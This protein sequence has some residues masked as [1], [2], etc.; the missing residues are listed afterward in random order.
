MSWVFTLYVH[1]IFYCSH[2]HQV[3][4]T[5]TAML[6][7]KYCKAVILSFHFLYSHDLNVW[8]RGDV[9]WRNL[10]LVSLRVLS[11]FYINPFSGQTQIQVQGGIWLLIPWLLSHLRFISVRYMYF[12]CLI[13]VAN[14]Y[15]MQHEERLYILFLE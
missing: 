5:Q 13:L 8:F 12:L 6:Q 1:C 11:S 15:F 10:M 2:R 3:A 4:F 14:F 7:G 9:E